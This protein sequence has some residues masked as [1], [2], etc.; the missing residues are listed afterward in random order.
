[1]T[2]I[3]TWFGYCSTCEVRWIWERRG[4]TE[5]DD[6]ARKPHCP[7]CGSALINPTE[8]SNKEFQGTTQV[9]TRESVGFEEVED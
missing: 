9:T 6:F 4:H 3:M 5:E 7:K 1:M 8:Q 2:L